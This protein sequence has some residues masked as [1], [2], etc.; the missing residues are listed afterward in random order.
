MKLVSCTANGCNVSFSCFFLLFCRQL[1]DLHNDNVYGSFSGSTAHSH[2]P[3]YSF[4]ASTGRFQPPPPIFTLHSR[5]L[6]LLAVFSPHH[7]FLPSIAHS[8][9][10]SA[11]AAHFLPPSPF[12]HPYHLF[13]IPTTIFFTSPLTFFCIASLTCFLALFNSHLILAAFSVHIASC[14]SHITSL[15]PRTAIMS[16]CQ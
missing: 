13:Y 16:L 7:P 2:P 12:F 4:S 8:L 11:S 6:P 3:N 14:K 10:L 1:L 5:F 15:N 9:P